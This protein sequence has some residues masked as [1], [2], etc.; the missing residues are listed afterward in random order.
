MKKTIAGAVFGSALLFASPSAFAAPAIG[1]DV[2]VEGGAHMNPTLPIIF[3]S[4]VASIIISAA[5]ANFRDNREL[6]APE[7]WSCGIL[8][9]FAAPTPQKKVVRRRR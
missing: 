9:W 7:A 5:V 3:G 1:G 6:T 8:Y 4:C 2:V